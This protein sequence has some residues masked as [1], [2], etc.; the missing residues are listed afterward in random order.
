MSWTDTGQDDKDLGE[1]GLLGD[2]TCIL[3]IVSVA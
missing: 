3:T 1:V 2:F